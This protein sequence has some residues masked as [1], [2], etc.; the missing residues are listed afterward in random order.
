MLNL[1]NS[2]NYNGIKGAEKTWDEFFRSQTCAEKT[3]YKF[4]KSQTC[5]EESVDL[6]LVIYSE[7]EDLICRWCNNI[8]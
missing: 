4:F 8:L 2:L 6:V 5:E 7:N 3:W 1:F